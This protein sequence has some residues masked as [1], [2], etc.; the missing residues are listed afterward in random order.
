MWLVQIELFCMIKVTQISK[1]WCEKKIVKY[2]TNN[3]L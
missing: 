3:F 2:L 1:I